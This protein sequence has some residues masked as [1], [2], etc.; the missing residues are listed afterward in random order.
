MKTMSL[1]VVTTTQWLCGNSSTWPHDAWFHI[2]GTNEP[3]SAQLA[4]QGT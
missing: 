4:K 2:T 1:P 3:K